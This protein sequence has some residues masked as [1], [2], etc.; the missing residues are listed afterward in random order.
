MAPLNGVFKKLPGA[1]RR[2]PLAVRPP[3]CFRQKGAGLAASCQW[4]EAHRGSGRRLA[5]RRSQRPAG[6][7]AATCVAAAVRRSFSSAAAAMALLGLTLAGCGAARGPVRLDP[8]PMDQAVGI[9]NGN[10]SRI[11]GT[12]RAS[13]TVDGRFADA[14]GRGHNFHLDGVL[15]FLAP[16][17]LRFDLK[18]FGERQLLFGANDEAYWVFVKADDAHYCGGQ[19]NDEDLPPD[20]PVRPGQIVD[21]LGLTPVAVPRGGEATTAAECVQ[22]VVEDY[23]QIL[24]LEHG[25]DGRLLIEREYWLDR[26]SPRLVRRVVFRDADG[27]VT[28]ESALDD[29]RPLPGQGPLLP[30]VLVADWPGNGTRM[31]FRVGKWTAVNEVLPGGPQFATPREC[32]HKAA[33]EPP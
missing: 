22:R 2:V 31:R 17:Y 30:H 16:S 5:G 26:C 32:E 4:Y 15:F 1:S 8:I 28:M 18:K 10:V 27:V 24:C 19:G 6:T 21:A 13:G 14:D 7:Q 23:Q 11:D 29:Y 3:L 9:V 20:V 12:L 25:L 33:A